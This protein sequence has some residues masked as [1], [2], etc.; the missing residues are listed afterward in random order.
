MINLIKRTYT[1][2][3]ANSSFLSPTFASNVQENERKNINY[4]FDLYDFLYEF[5]LTLS[6]I[7]GY[8][9][10]INM[11]ADRSEKSDPGVIIKNHE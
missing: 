11:K 6:Q 7:F 9:L 1:S 5:G 2:Q 8:V 4:N 3:S 10:N